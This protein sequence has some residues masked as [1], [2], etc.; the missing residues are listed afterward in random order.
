MIAFHH[1]STDKTGHPETECAARGCSGD[2]R[3]MADLARNALDVQDACNLSGVVHS[4]SRDIA[5]LR[6][7]TDSEPGFSTSKL[8]EHPICRLYADKIASLS[9]SESA[10]SPAYAWATK[11]AGR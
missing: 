4:F 1:P 8:N 11:A 5:R 2:N 9:G 10:F 3:T 6:Q 7:L